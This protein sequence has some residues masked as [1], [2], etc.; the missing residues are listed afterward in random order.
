MLNNAGLGS[1]TET[2]GLKPSYFSFFFVMG[3]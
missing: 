2:I 1:V 3:F